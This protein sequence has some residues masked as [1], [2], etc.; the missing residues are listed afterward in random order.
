MNDYQKQLK[1]WQAKPFIK[2][3]KK[4]LPQAEIFLVGGAVRDIILGRETKDF[5]FVI[6]NVSKKNLEKFLLKL[7]KVNLV[8][9]KFGVFKFRP[10]GWQG[11]DI[12]IALPR[13]EHSIG[14]TC[15]SRDFKI[16]SNAKLK[17]EDD[18]SRRDFTINAMAWDINQSKLIDPFNGLSDLKN[19]IIKTVGKAELRFKEDY[20]RMLRAIRFAVQLN[21][22]AGKAGFEI[23]S[24]TWQ[25]I[26]KSIQ[27][28]NKKINGEWVVAREIIAKELTK[29][30]SAQPVLALELLDKSNTLKHLMPELLRS[31]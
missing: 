7:G 25:T 9:K 10:R 26:K 8:G 23:E 31:E 5:D 1:A 15:G 14:M 24:K 20:S 28:L 11:E 16:Q 21:L 6:R 2:Q 4:Q 22:P 13:T 18:L 12:D 3:L 27:N 30:I 29:A 17:I 19:K